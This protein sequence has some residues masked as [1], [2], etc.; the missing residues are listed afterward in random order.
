MGCNGV[1]SGRAS[2][3]ESGAEA[4]GQQQTAGG[5]SGRR[6]SLLLNT[7]SAPACL[8]RTQIQTEQLDSPRLLHRSND[9]AA[10]GAGAQARLAGNCCSPQFLQF[11]PSR[12]VRGRLARCFGRTHGDT[13]CGENRALDRPSAPRARLPS[14]G[15]RRTQQAARLSLHLEPEIRLI[16]GARDSASSASTGSA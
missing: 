3:R 1:T 12:G 11:G 13:D 16:L 9:V 4:E 7:R 10:V 8:E 14:R 6:R 2:E 5:D 15:N